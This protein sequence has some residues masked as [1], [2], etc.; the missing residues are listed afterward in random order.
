MKFGVREIIFLIVLLAVPVASFLYVFKPRNNEIQQAKTEVA[1][2]QERL[3][4]L[5]EMTAKIDDLGLEIERGKEA[6][7]LIEAKLPSQDDVAGLLGQFTQLAKANDMSVPSFKPMP[8][9]PAGAYNELPIE[10]VMEGRFDNFYQFLLELERLP[11]ITRI[12]TMTLEQTSID[13]GMGTGRNKR[14]GRRSTKP[15]SEE[16]DLPPGSMRAELTL[17]IYFASAD[18]QND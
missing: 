7:E 14:S 9:V 13:V 3:E 11:R 18:G 16:V 2:K 6:I 4:R 12:H 8:T 1:E 15:A 5:E 17:S 10:M